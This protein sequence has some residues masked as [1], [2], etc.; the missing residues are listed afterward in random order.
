MVT[1]KR[2][3]NLLVSEKYRAAQ[4][5]KPHFFRNNPLL[6]MY[7]SAS[8]CKGVGNIPGSHFVNTFPAL[9]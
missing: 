4:P 7:T 2:F 8:D 6:H 3:G 1:S 9:P 5:R